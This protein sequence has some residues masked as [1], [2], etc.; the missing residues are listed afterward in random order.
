MQYRVV[1]ADS[2]KADAERL[3]QWVTERAPLRGPEWFDRLLDS[4]YS[5]DH[6]PNR[7]PLVQ[8]ARRSHREIRNL[9][10]GKRGNVYRILFEVDEKRNI[11]WI[12]HIRRGPRAPLR[13]EDL[14][15]P[16]GR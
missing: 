7:C 14:A 9:L 13:P 1:L 16:G 8:E 3:Y 4:L 15:K 11:V 10:Y 6:S 2:A 5:L 12:P